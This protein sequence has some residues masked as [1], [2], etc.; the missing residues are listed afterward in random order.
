MVVIRSRGSRCRTCTTDYLTK[1]LFLKKYIYKMAPQHLVSILV[2]NYNGIE[3]CQDCF[4]S[5]RALTYP[6]Y[7]VIMIDNLSTDGSVAYVRKNF[8][9]VR[10]IELD[11]NYGFAKGNNRGVHF[12]R[13]KYL[14][15]L[16]QDTVLEKDCLT[17][18]VQVMDSDPE[19]GM[20]SAKM[21]FWSEKHVINSTGLIVNKI[22]CCWDRGSFELDL[23][24]YDED[25]EVVS[26]S[27]GAMLIRKDVFEHLGGFDSEY[28]MYYEDLDLGLRTWLS[29]YKV[30]F[31]PKSV[32]YHKMQYSYQKYYHFEYIDHRNRL[33]TILK[34]ISLKNL[35][36][37]LSLS[38][39]NDVRCILS[40][41]YSRRFTF[42][43]YR[44][45][46]LLWN[47][48]MLPNTLHERRK[49]QKQRIIS[50]NRLLHMMAPGFKSPELPVAVPSYPVNYKDSLD[51]E[52]V[53]PDLKMGEGDE[54]QLGFGWYA[55]ENW[56]GK[57]IRWTTN[58]AIAFLKMCLNENKDG[59]QGIEIEMFSPLK[60]KGQLYLNDRP[61]GELLFNESGW[62]LFTFRIMD[63]DEIQKVTI[64]VPGFAPKAITPKSND[65]RLLGVA[66]SRLRVIEL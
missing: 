32:I 5:I 53:K 46:A 27:G 13:G 52:G 48:R 65:N 49:I 51:R 60:T 36:W 23:G 17:E 66:V 15:F 26:V 1:C 19:I 40:W 2:L 57:Q 64:V 63:E 11:N 18:L 37:M 14:F 6:H 38:L 44:I 42:I 61:V 54:G 25:T 43:K 3:F 7:E 20:C 21:M 56:D 22:C 50:D 62:K 34:N 29:G 24:Q 12:A 9:E 31:V 59:E 4:T 10:I 58:F 16:N 47:V 35:L 39:L 41:L 45:M 30:M 8:P 28:F 33:R 55:C